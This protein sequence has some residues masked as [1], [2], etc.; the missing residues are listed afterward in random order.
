MKRSVLIAASGFAF[1]AA[2][3]GYTKVI[4][5]S[6][7]DD[8]ADVSLCVGESMINNGGKLATYAPA[9]QR[10]KAYESS[11]LWLLRRR[12]GA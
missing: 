2:L 4:W 11:P 5:Q 12:H 3:V 8:G 9:C 6:G 10:A 7:F 1:V